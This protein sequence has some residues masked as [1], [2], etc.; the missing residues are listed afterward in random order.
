MEKTISLGKIDLDEI[1]RKDNLVEVYLRLDKNKDNISDFIQPN[2]ITNPA[3]KGQATVSSKSTK[4]KGKVDWSKAPKLN[5]QKRADWYTKNNL[6]Q[7]KTTKVK[8]N[9][10]SK[11]VNVKKIEGTNT[12]VPSLKD[13]MDNK[14]SAT[15]KKKKS[16]CH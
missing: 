5:T 2:S 12:S 9:K 14:R 16:G 7:D 4:T 15:P 8:K 11:K 6:K 10:N 1:G 3:P 13:W